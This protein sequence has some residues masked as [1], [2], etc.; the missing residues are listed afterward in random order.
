MNVVR[1]LTLAAVVLAQSHILEKMDD[2][3][4]AMYVALRSQFALALVKP[5]EDNRIEITYKDSTVSIEK[6]GKKYRVKTPE[7]K[8]G[9]LCARLIDVRYFLEDYF[10]A[11]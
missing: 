11:K 4:A 3:F 9:K 10:D 6:A 1:R 8:K 5:F 2:D 7:N